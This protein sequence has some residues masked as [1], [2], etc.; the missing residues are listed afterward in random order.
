MN[1]VAIRLQRD[2]RTVEHWCERGLLHSTALAGGYGGVWVAVTDEG[3]PVDGPN[4]KAYSETRS[5][6]CR[7]RE[8]EKAARTNAELAEPTKSARRRKQN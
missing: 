4:V 3:W 8:A 6:A 1:E 2:V 5:E 7:Q